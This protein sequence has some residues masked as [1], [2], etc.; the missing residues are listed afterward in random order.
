MVGSF[1]PGVCLPFC[2]GW[3][4]LPIQDR[5]RCCRHIQMWHHF[6]WLLVSGWTVIFQLEQDRWEHYWPWKSFWNPPEETNWAEPLARRG[7][8]A[9]DAF[10][11]WP[12][13]V[14]GACWFVALH[15]GQNPWT[16]SVL[17]EEWVQNG[18]FKSVPRGPVWFGLE[19]S[20]RPW[21]T[22]I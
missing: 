9:E 20:G 22:N 5:T 21:R 1:G 4:F 7:E 19:C 11:A 6:G 13:S 10:L 2:T 8:D 16:L 14:L 12:L 18:T 3:L 15:V 17:S